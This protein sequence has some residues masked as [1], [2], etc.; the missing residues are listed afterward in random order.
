VTD[1][2]VETGPP[3]TF[4]LAAFYQAARETNV[5]LAYCARLAGTFL[6]DI[7]LDHPARR[8]WQVS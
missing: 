7:F 1:S 5:F 2:C 8:F 6:L 4:I 3:N